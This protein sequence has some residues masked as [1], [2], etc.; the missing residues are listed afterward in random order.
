MAIREI[1]GSETASEGLADNAIVF[2][3]RHPKLPIGGLLQTSAI[4]NRDDARLVEPSCMRPCSCAMLLPAGGPDLAAE[5]SL[6]Y[7]SYCHFVW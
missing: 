7:R 2:S 3:F 6:I 4:E 5:N 1:V